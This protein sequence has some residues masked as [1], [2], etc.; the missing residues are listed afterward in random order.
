MACIDSEGLF[1]YIGTGF[2][3]RNNDG[4]IFLASVTKP[5]IDIPSPSRLRNDDMDCG[6]HVYY[7]SDKAFLVRHYLL[8]LYP[9]RVLNNMKRIFNY[10][11]SG[12][13]QLSNVLLV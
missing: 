9:Q 10:R 8:R 3:S 6:F 5:F 7:V 1:P 13:E 2:D 12:E 4:G 11:L